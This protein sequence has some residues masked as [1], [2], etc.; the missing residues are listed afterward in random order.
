MG[1]P[2]SRDGRHGQTRH[3]PL[4]TGPITPAWIHSLVSRAPS[5]ACPWFPIWV[6]TPA[7]RAGFGQ[8]TSF[9]QSMRHWFLAI[10]VLTSADGRHCRDG[11][12]V[13]G[14]AN[15]NGID[16]FRLFV[17]QEPK[18]FV[19]SRFGKGLK[20]TGRSFIVDVT[21]GDDIGP[22]AC[23]GSDVAAAHTTG[24]DTCDIQSLTGCDESC[25]A[26][27]VPGY[28]SK[29][30]CRAAGGCEKTSA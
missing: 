12:D 28:K 30:E 18:I 22:Q 3:E 16:V 20:R 14:R 11:M 7:A 8:L 5:V 21:Q 19:S 6:A 13:I 1:C 2:A 9:V 29:P 17:E 4:C 15:R 26:Q 25:T 23:D 24:T 27:D 10:D